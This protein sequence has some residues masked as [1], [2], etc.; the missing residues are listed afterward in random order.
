M[1]TVGMLSALILAT[2]A[3]LGGCGVGTYHTPDVAPVVM[4]EPEEDIFADLDFDTDSSESSSSEGEKEQAP[5][6]E[7]PKSED[8]APA[9]KKGEA[10]GDAE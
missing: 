3:C 10:K 8:A 6:A 4:P 7:E 5:P 9:P 2:V 1:K